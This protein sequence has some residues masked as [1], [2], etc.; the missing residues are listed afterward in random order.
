MDASMA[1][2]NQDTVER[3]YQDFLEE[4]EEDQ[5]YRKHVNI[6]FSE[7]FCGLCSC[8]G[9]VTSLSLSLSPFLPPLL[10]LTLP[11]SLPSLPFFILLS[12][13]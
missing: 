5:M 1:T 13:P 12:R 11:L 6:Y 9:V 10:P 8:N 7:L 4:L 2:A 3:D